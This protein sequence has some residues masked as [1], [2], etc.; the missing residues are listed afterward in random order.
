MNANANPI[1]WSQLCAWRLKRQFLLDRSSP[2][3]LLEVVSRL[4]GV[5][6]QLA[7]AAE[8]ALLARIDGLQRASVGEALWSQ[9]SL[10]KTW[11]MRGT[12]HLVNPADLPLHV[13]AHSA[14]PP[15]RP[16][17]YYSYH[18]ITPEGLEA[19]LENVPHALSD[20]PITREQLATAVAEQ[21]G[22]PDLRQV[23]LSGWGALLKPSAF[24]GDLCFG[25]N[26]GQNV[27]F[28][29]PE[30]WIGPWQAD[31]DPQDAMR[32]VAR[33]YLRTYGPANPSDF[34]RWWG[35]E[36]SRGKKVFKLLEA[37]I[38]PVS[39]EGWEAWYLSETLEAMQ[40]AGSPSSL[41]LL[42]QFDAY[43]LGTPRDN[44]F[45]IPEEHKTRIYRPQAW[46]SAVVLVDGR[47][48]GVW[49]LKGKEEVKVEMF[50]KMTDEIQEGIDEEA[51]RLV[52]FTS[53]S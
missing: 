15:R 14:F 21:A 9:R 39:M 42:P 40:S 5:Q 27:T 45:V 37:E 23:L 1:T 48:Q 49:E 44:S 13:A 53:D 19:I 2:E 36:A 7:S 34:A 30:A 10:V 24:R 47:M 29:R 52:S 6:A 41:R 25:P 38:S 18:G 17:S 8:L 46:I 4:G 33:R 3:Q 43:T 11:A 32:E 50:G 12:L 16:P 20:Q 26:Q 35:I 51:K 22:M 31:L 28:V